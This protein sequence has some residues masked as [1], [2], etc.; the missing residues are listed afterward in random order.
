MTAVG[1]IPAAHPATTSWATQAD[2]VCTVWK[3]KASTAFGTSQPKTVKA[4]YA[5]VTKARPFEVGE[6]DALRKITLPRPAAASKALSFAAG[7]IA[8]IDHAIAAYRAGKTSLF[9]RDAIAWLD[10]HRT[11]RAFVAAG[12]RSCA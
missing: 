7:D 4:L 8:E 3:H 1:T 12:A 10:D 5:F 2:K 6:L 11:S 9:E